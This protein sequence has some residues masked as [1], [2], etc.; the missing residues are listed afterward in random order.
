MSRRNIRF[1]FEYLC[2]RL[3]RGPLRWLPHAWVRR[4]GRVIGA[5]AYYVLGARRRLTLDNLA[6][7]L[8]EYDE[9]GRKRMARACFAHFGATFCEVVSAAGFR[10]DRVDQYFQIEG[11]ENL[12][13]ALAQNRGVF[14]MT[15]HLGAWELAAYPLGLRLPRLEMVARPPNNPWI[16]EELARFRERFNNHLIAKSGAVGRILQAVREKATVAMVIDFRAGRSGVQIPFLGHPAWF[17]TVM[18]VVALHRRTPIVPVFCRPEG[19]AG[20][21][22]VIHPPILPEGRGEDAEI[23]LMRHCLGLVER[24]V[25][26]TPEQWMWMHD[27]WRY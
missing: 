1:A 16:A 3:V 18:A 6:R 11:E 24:E 15:G 19:N 25:R 21:R 4:L 2:Y 8:P 23:A 10:P 26:R 14:I 7:A 20:Y 9:R 13:A 22:I 27:L 17:H 12:R 5:A